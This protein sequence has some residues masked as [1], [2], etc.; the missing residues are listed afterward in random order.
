[1]IT[2]TTTPMMQDVAEKLKENSALNDTLTA[3]K[4]MP[5]PSVKGKVFSTA[6]LWR[7]RRQ[8]RM[9]GLVIR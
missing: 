7:L 8:S 9:Q 6:D 3:E 5:I 2:P 4:P 1:M